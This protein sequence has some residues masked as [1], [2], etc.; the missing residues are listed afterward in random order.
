MIG[1]VQRAPGILLSAMLVSGLAGA[2]F[3]PN[4]QQGLLCSAAGSCPAGQSCSDGVCYK[5]G[6]A[7]TQDA[8]VDA[9][10]YV[11]IAQT[12]SGGQAG[13]TDLDA[14]DD[15][16]VYWT[17]TG[18]T[19]V[20]RSPKEVGIVEVFH[21]SGLGKTPF[22]VAT[23]ATDVY[24]TEK[25]VVGRV[26][27]KAK[28]A[29]PASPA[30]EIAIGQGEPSHLAVDETHVYWSNSADGTIN[31]VPKGG[32]VVEILAMD[33][34]TPTVLAIDDTR[35]FW[36]N[37][38][39]G[40]IMRVDKTGIGL[41]QLAGAQVDPTDI[42]ITD[43]AVFWSATGDNEIRRVDKDGGAVSTVV[44]AEVGVAD[45]TL[46]GGYLYWSNSISGDIQ[47]QAIG[48]STRELVAEEQSEAVALQFAESLYWLNSLDA[49]NRL[50]RASCNSL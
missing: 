39:T 24:W 20:L 48:D 21:D 12:L 11:C 38:A 1:S 29:A 30:L 25:D 9:F 15:D 7:P 36:V 16:S 34:G 5:F 32:G 37:S 35:V 8:A 10:A 18:G 45:L 23:D 44:A 33:Q 3:E 41:Q 19:L 14:Q 50:V 2:C 6:T 22:G 47:R 28:S 13:A 43:A 31:R 26:L 49:T 4:T 42:A 40:Q 27:H 46:N 17:G